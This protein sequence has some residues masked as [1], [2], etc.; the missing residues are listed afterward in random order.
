MWFRRVSFAALALMQS[1]LAYAQ[2]D[3]EQEQPASASSAVELAN[4]LMLL[5]AVAYASADLVL[6]TQWQSWM[7]PGWA[8]SQAVAGGGNLGVSVWAFAKSRPGLGIAN[9]LFGAWFITHSVLSLLYY[10]PPPPK[11]KKQ[12][13]DP[14]AT[15]LPRLQ[16]DVGDVGLSA[17]WQF[18]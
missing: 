18:Q 13:I 8:W 3:G 2:V 7:S 9:M 11:E 17:N 15:W 12:V 5:S 6:A 16:L 1:G 10:Q 14:L 4:G